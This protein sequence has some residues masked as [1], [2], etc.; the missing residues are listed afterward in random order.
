MFEHAW[1][2]EYGRSNRAW[3]TMAG[4]AGQALLIAGVVLMP[5]VGPQALPRPQS[6][7]TLFY[8]SAPAAPPPPAPAQPAMA[9]PRAARTPLQLRA[10]RLM[11]PTLV[12]ER[13][14]VLVEPPLAAAE[15]G[16]AGGGVPGGVE[17]GIPGGIL[18]G[19][20]SVVAAQ[21][22]PPLPARPAAPPVEKPKPVE[23]ITVG[24]NVQQ[25]RLIHEVMPV[26]PV[27][28]RQ[29]RISGEVELLGVIGTDGRI[30][31]LRLVSGHPL[32]APAALEAVRQWI[33]RPTYLNGD[34]VEVEAPIVVN[35][36]M[37]P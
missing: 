25:G 29:A 26:Y 8:P 6:L 23:R 34:P 12:P 35:F 11:A 9:A 13:A 7:V 5:L 21:A 24:G 27:L 19:L 10:G 36:V 33:Y 22:A 2:V 14:V 37:N 18:H 20:P 1:A 31:E 4:F 3:T 32:L 17:G 28:A 16:G 15:L 30:R